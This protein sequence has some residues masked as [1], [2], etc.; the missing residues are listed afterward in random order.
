MLLFPKS[1]VDDLLTSVRSCV[2]SIKN[3]LK[4]DY[5]IEKVG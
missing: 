1:A 2:L 3:S 4:A 5:K